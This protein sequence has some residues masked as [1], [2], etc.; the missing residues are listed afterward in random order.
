MNPVKFQLFILG[1]E[2][3]QLANNLTKTKRRILLFNKHI[4][5]DK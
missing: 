2:A 3:T 5:Y 4:Q 1:L